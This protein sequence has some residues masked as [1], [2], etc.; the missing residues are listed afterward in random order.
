VVTV[1]GLEPLLGS[2]RL[3][4]A[5][6]PFANDPFQAQRASGLEY[7]VGRRPSRLK[8]SERQAKWVFS[9]EVERFIGMPSDLTTDKISNFVK[10]AIEET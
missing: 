4:G 3:V 5:V 10:M 8:Q 2:A 1:F 7:T 6:D 9:S